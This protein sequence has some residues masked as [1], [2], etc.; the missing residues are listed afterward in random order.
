MLRA[1]PERTHMR[2]ATFQEGMRSEALWVQTVQRTGTLHLLPHGPAGKTHP[3]AIGFAVTEQLFGTLRLSVYHEPYQIVEEQ[4]LLDRRA[5]DLLDL[6]DD[7]PLR[8]LRTNW[9]SV[10]TEI[11]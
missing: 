8:R 3:V 1:G 7:L 11:R 6:C 2:N 10:P 9:I 5:G 4:T